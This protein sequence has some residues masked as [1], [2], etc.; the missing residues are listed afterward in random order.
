MAHH[1][2]GGRLGR[3]EVGARVGRERMHLVVDG[4][5]HAWCALEVHDADGVDRDVDTTGR[6]GHGIGVRVH[7]RLV[8]HVAL[9]DGRVASEAFDIGVHGVEPTP[10]SPGEMHRGAL[11]GQGAGDGPAD[12][13]PTFVDNGVLVR[14]RI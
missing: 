2:P 10:G 3:Q 14:E 5:L 9:G 6:G 4:Q 11:A 12:R 7:R 13:P 8:E 1:V